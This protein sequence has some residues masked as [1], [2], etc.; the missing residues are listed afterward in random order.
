[1]V[2]LRG[3]GAYVWKV[4]QGGIRDRTNLQTAQ[5]Y[6]R[7][8]AERLSEGEFDLM[9]KLFV[10]LVVC[11]LSACIFAGCITTEGAYDVVFVSEGETFFETKAKFGAAIVPPEE[12]PVKTSQ[13]GKQFEFVGWSLTDGGEVVDPTSVTVTGDVA[14]YAVFKAVEGSGETPGG[15]ETSGGEETPDDEQKPSYTVTFKDGLTGETIDEVSVEYGGAATAPTAPVHE[16]YTFAGWNGDFDEIKGRTQ[17]TAL[18]TVNSYKLTASVLGDSAEQSVNYGDEIVLD[19]PTAPEGLSFV[20]WTIDGEPLPDGATMPA[21]DVT[22]VAKFEIDWTGVAIDE[23]DVASVVYGG[24]ISMDLPAIDGMTFSYVWKD[25]TEDADFVPGSAGQTALEVVVSATYAYEGGTIEGGKTLTATANVAKAP[26][27]VVVTLDKS[28]VVYG[29]ALP[30]ATVTA[31]GWIGGDERAISAYVDGAQDKFEVGEYTYTA[32]VRGLNNYDAQVTGAKFTVEQKAL[33]MTVTVANDKEGQGVVYGQEPEVVVAF[34]GFV[35]GDGEDVVTKGEFVYS[36]GD[37]EYT[38]QRLAV[39]E[40]TVTARGYSAKNYSIAEASTSF[41]V[42][43]APLTIAA[44]SSADSYTY[45]AKPSFVTNYSG[46]VP[47]EDKSVLEGSAKFT[48]ARADGKEFDEDM[49]V[50]GSYTVSVIGYDAQNYDITY[51]ED[52]F[53]VTKYKV[54]IEAP[55]ATVNAGTAWSKSDFA[56]TLPTGH[57]FEGTLTMEASDV[58]TYRSDDVEQ[59]GKFSWTVDPRVLKG[60]ADMTENFEFATVVEVEVIA[61]D[62][63][64]GQIDGY[65]AEYTGKAQPLGKGIEVANSEEL[66]DFKIVY[67]LSEDDMS[68]SIPTAT[69]VGEYPVYFKISAKNHSDYSGSY[70]A[71]ITKAQNEIAAKGEWRTYAYGENVDWANNLTA[72]FGTT[73]L[74]E[75]QSTMVNTADSEFSFEVYVP[76]GDNWLGAKYTVTVDTIKATLTE[77]DL[78]EYDAIVD[79]DKIIVGANKTLDDI[80]LN[81]GYE[82]VHPDE[83]YSLGENTGVEIT[84]C[85]DERYYNKYETTVDFTA[86]KEK[87][88][89]TPKSGFEIDIDGALPDFLAGIFVTDESGKSQT[90]PDGLVTAK[91]VNYLDANDTEGANVNTVGGTYPVIFT[92]VEAVAES[93][94]YYDPVFERGAE[95]FTAYLKVKSV[96]IGDT[97][98]LYTIEDALNTA[99]SDTVIV[100][101]DTAFADASVKELAYNGD[102]YYTVKSGVTLLVPYDGN[103]STSANNYLKDDNTETSATPYVTLTMTEGTTLTV[104]DGGSLLVNAS[105]ASNGMASSHAINYGKL[106]TEKDTK[107]V[108]ESDSWADAT[109]YITGSGEMIAESGSSIYE[110]FNLYGWKG[111]SISSK[112]KGKVFPINQYT[113]NNLQIN[114]TFNAGSYYYAKATIT[115]TIIGR[116]DTKVAF[117]SPKSDAFIEL[118]SGTLKKSY[119]NT[120]G[121]VRFAMNGNATFHNLEVKV[122]AASASTK[123]LQV[124][125]PGHFKLTVASGTTTIPSDVQIKLLPG[126]ELNINS[127]ATL[128]VNGALYAYADINDAYDNGLTKWQDGGNNKQYPSTSHMRSTS[129]DKNVTPDYS[130]DTPAKITVN[131]NI[132]VASGATLGAVIGG[133]SGTLIMDAGA[134]TQGSFTEDLSPALGLLDSPKYFEATLS[135]KFNDGTEIAA[136]KTYTCIGGVWA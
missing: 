120:N 126:A 28:K 26:L 30:T 62:F 21:K 5:G 58:G 59:E 86:R 16:G 25:G 39:G 115:A 116:V 133:E 15:E 122:S 48:I 81:D 60:E 95:N 128:N 37:G 96:S 38:A 3:G 24:G 118:S 129:I 12:T 23:T 42:I 70:T 104:K 68:E 69:N 7:E 103:Y 56:P 113:L 66:E 67:G 88:T 27:G 83:G 112:I 97:S 105:I 63:E 45:G 76:E 136:G 132:N 102:G 117:V 82:W 121:N 47:G 46:F 127:G 106:V 2:Q 44:V 123:K 75:G 89:I 108:L 71:N 11:A 110:V 18:Y 33:T 55:P 8:E 72:K 73:A 17:I 64:I 119:V 98:T 91:A 134:K 131:G 90:L 125:I 14:L 36:N 92:I 74:K 79:R 32:D 101:Y 29:G 20:C 31:T 94:E 111:G 22:A 43:K 35:D 107:I 114:T 41:E 52:S 34:D 93:I 100:K 10:A 87:L 109:G 65:S 135:A 84:Y 51:K 4:P 50:V 40:Y 124:P 80:K 49:P 19:A 99:S 85:P 61:I 13:D 1:M 9:K 78:P 54:E 130:A 77:D 6:E 53:K 57:T